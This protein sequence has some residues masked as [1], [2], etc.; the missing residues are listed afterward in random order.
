MGH[1]SASDPRT[2][3]LR[4]R[5]REDTPFWAGGVKRG[6]KGELIYPKPSEFQGC[7]KI[8]NKQRKLV[9]CIAHPWQLE[10]DDLLERQR[11]AGKPMRAIILKARKLGFSTWVAVKFL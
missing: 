9:P 4:R 11:A 2:E 6:A 1:A 7:V 10:F 5:L 8:L 3:A